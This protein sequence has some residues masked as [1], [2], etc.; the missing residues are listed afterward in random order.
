MLRLWRPH[1]QLACVAAVTAHDPQRQSQAAATLPDQP[2]EVQ[3]GP[4][5]ATCAIRVQLVASCVES[6]DAAEVDHARSV[7]PARLAGRAPRTSGA[8]KLPG[9]DSN[10]RGCGTDDGVESRSMITAL[11]DWLDRLSAWTRGEVPASRLPPDHTSYRPYRAV[12]I[13]PGGACCDAAEEWS[14]ER[15]LTTQAP[16]L[17][18]QDCTKPDTCRCR[19]Q[20]FADRRQATDRRAGFTPIE[21]DDRRRRA[22][23]RTHRLQF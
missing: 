17:P 15:F 22:D 9:L 11:T 21:H 14:Y 5:S 23:R 3:A 1:L 8:G 10:P 13:E 18:L 6:R 2:L 4:S 7:I 12:A 19:Y 20:K 16:R